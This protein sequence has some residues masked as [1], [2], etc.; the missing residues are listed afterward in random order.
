MFRTAFHPPSVRPRF[1]GAKRL[2]ILRLSELIY[3]LANFMDSLLYNNSQ[4]LSLQISNVR[5]DPLGTSRPRF[6]EGLNNQT[7]QTRTEERE[8]LRPEQTR[9]P[10]ANPK[11]KRE[12]KQRTN[13]T[14]I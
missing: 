10:K 12:D 8:Q 5:A 1:R 7:P 13:T 14:L 2:F 3:H 9:E 6:V 4:V 11:P